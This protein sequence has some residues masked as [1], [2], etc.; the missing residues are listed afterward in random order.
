MHPRSTY[1]KVRPMLRAGFLDPYSRVSVQC[2]LQFRPELQLQRLDIRQRL[3]LDPSRGLTD[4]AG[5]FVRLGDDVEFRSRWAIA[6]APE[7][8]FQTEKP[9]S[10]PSNLVQPI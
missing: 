1:C 7:F 5:P 8:D 3:R 9:K 4:R 6:D 10:L 2:R